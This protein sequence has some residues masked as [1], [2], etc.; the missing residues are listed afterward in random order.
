[1]NPIQEEP[2]SEARWDQFIQD[3]ETAPPDYFSL[4]DVTTSSNSFTNINP[5]AISNIYSEDGNAITGLGWTYQDTNRGS[6]GP[7]AHPVPDIKD[8]AAY[9]EPQGQSDQYRTDQE[10]N[11]LLLE[12]QAHHVPDTQFHQDASVYEE[13]EG[14]IDQYRTDLHLCAVGIQNLE[15][16]YVQNIV[17]EI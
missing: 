13:P 14:Q 3:Y 15:T 7:Q 16:Q 9:E 5:L 2:F 4:D 8:P 17:L 6:L 12:P 1:M 11:Q 10:R